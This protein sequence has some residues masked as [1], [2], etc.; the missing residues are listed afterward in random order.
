MSN[1]PTMAEALSL[2]MEA[3]LRELH[4]AIPARVEAYDAATQKASVQPLIRAKRVDV[5]GDELVE[6]LPLIIGVP[7]VFPA[8]GGFRLTFPVVPGDTVLLVF[9]EASLDVWLQTG[10][11]V[12]PRDDRRNH[13]SDAI[14]IPGLHPFNAA[15][16]GAGSGNMTMGKDGGAQIAITPTEVHLG[17]ENAPN[18]V[19]V[20][21]KVAAALN[22]FKTR[23]VASFGASAASFLDG[24][25]S[26]A[27]A[28][29]LPLTW[30][31]FPLGVG[32]SSVKVKP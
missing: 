21:A 13:L 17:Q 8:A 26:L 5:D 15:H 7:V 16:T 23:L 31:G 19:A 14:A 20:D 29:N 22:D 6:R 30:A 1:S 3:R 9:S 25:T 11:D 12:D 27:A 24:G 28:M 2:I 18:A 4:V 10:G 32:S